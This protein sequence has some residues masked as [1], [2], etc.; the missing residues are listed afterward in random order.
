[1]LPLLIGLAFASPDLDQRDSPG[2]RPGE[3]W[4]APSIE[5]SIQR[6]KLTQ[7]RSLR[8]AGVSLS[9]A[10]PPTILVGMGL[11]IGGVFGERPTVG[12][13]GG[14]VALTGAAAGLAGPPLIL[15]GGA[16]AGSTLDPETRGRG[17][18]LRIVGGGLFGLA[19]LSLFAL[20]GFDTDIALGTSFALY[21]GGVTTSWIGTNKAI[22]RA[23]YEGSWAITPS[24]TPHHQGVRL[25][26][27]R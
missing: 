14:V 19:V 25:V 6:R 27:V 3:L 24:I 20:Q 16:V 4:S 11:I 17:A 2:D 22:Q 5:A 13:A 7:A 9:I 15:G 23:N 18:G 1:M 21:V 10:A 8:N 26:V 12:A